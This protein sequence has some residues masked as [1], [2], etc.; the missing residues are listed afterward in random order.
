MLGNS[1]LVRG[2]ERRI[3]EERINAER[4]VMDEIAQVAESFAEMGDAYLAAQVDDIR[5]V[6]ARLVRNLTKTPYAAI[7][8]LPEGTVILAEELTPADT[9]LIVRST[10]PA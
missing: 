10:A 2:A 3:E 1:R 5:V 9:A 7:Q 6:G 8:G 4:A